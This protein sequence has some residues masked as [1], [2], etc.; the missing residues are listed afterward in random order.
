MARK[1]VSKSV[2]S[3]NVATLTVDNFT[4]SFTAGDVAAD[5]IRAAIA[6]ETKNP[7][8]P[9]AEWLAA[10]NAGFLKIERAA[11]ADP[12]VAKS[13]MSKIDAA[14]A[15]ARKMGIANYGKLDAKSGAEKGLWYFIRRP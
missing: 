13:P 12:K 1:T 8:Y 2:S 15:R 5:A 4:L 6:R 11:S 7:W 10:Q 14:I 9:V 3:K